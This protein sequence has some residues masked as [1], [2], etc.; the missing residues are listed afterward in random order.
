[1][2]HVTPSF[3]PAGSIKRRTQINCTLR[4]SRI[5]VRLPTPEPQIYE[6][7]VS[8]TPGEPFHMFLGRRGASNYNRASSSCVTPCRLGTCCRRT[9]DRVPSCRLALSRQ[10]ARFSSERD[11]SADGHAF[12]RKPSA[13]DQERCRCWYGVRSHVRRNAFECWD[14]LRS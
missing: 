2:S 9:R 6:I 3:P 1:M 7:S 10:R 8:V 13:T 5:S 11:E 14:V 4:D 12:H